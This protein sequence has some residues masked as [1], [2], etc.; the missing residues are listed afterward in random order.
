[1]DL[2]ER[3][4]EVMR[5]PINPRPGI[6]YGPAVNPPWRRAYAEAIAAAV[7]DHYAKGQSTETPPNG[8]ETG[9]DN[10]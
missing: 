1:M 2:V 6:V 9:R 7:E 8:Q 10:A 3:I 5:G 4:D